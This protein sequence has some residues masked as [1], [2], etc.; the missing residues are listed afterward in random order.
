MGTRRVRGLSHDGCAQR[1]RRR[2]GAP[3]HALARRRANLLGADCSINMNGDL[4]KNSPLFLEDQELML[5]EPLGKS[6]VL[7]IGSGQ[8]ITLACPGKNNKVSK[9]LLPSCLQPLTA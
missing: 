7:K 6:G 1:A 4:A 3:G 9:G 8:Q 5:P 2:Q